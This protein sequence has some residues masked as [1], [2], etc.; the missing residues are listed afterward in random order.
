MI[1]TIAASTL[2][3]LG[4]LSAILIALT[5]SVWRFWV[6]KAT[7]NAAKKILGL[8]SASFLVASLWIVWKFQPWMPEGKAK[9]ISSTRLGDY[10][11]QT[12]QTKN[13]EVTEPF[14]TWLFARKQGHKWMPFMLDFEDTYRPSISLRKEGSGI[15]ILRGST[16]LGVFDEMQQTFTRSPDGAVFPSA[17]I[18]SEPPGN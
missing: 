1:M 5:L 15:L 18:D 16:K 12:W 10:D 4:I 14:T 6:S 13:S 17:E 7:S 2:M 11:F 9:R 8:L 3:I